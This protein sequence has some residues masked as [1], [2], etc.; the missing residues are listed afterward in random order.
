MKK[1][2]EYICYSVSVL[3]IAA[4]VFVYLA[5][6]IGWRVDSVE[7]GS[8]EPE[9]KV[10]S[11]VVVQPVDPETIVEGDIITFRLDGVDETVITHRVI[12]IERNSPLYFRTRGD[13]NLK[14]DP[15]AI[16]A[17]DVVG[18]VVLNIPF[19]GYVTKYLKTF[20][21]FMFT[22][23]I[24]GTAVVVIYAWSVWREFNQNKKNQ[25]KVLNSER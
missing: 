13:A 18:R 14:P 3:L 21:G 20:V 19:L 10:G 1:A 8:M 4:A 12:G 11:V 16:R 24:P 7:S 6:H 23:I 15:F 9:L 2:V 22:V 5:P 25:V 17:R